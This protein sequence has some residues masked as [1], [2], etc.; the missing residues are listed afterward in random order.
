MMKFNISEDNTIRLAEAFGNALEN[1]DMDRFYSAFKLHFKDKSDFEICLSN[2]NLEKSNTARL[3]YFYSVVTQEIRHAGVVLIAI[4]SIMEATAQEEFQ[5]FDQWLLHQLKG[6]KNISFPINDQHNFKKMILLRQKEYYS[7][8]GSSQKVHN[9]VDNYFSDEDK[10]KLIGGFQ[11]RNEPANHESLNFDDKI[12]I[13]VDMLYKERN[14]FVHKARLPQLSDQNVKM[15]G[16][17]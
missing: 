17:L 5:P 13:I 2:L 12:K 15:L 3:G 8:H 9:F 4:F 10:Q 7:R 16:C 14:A 6:V 1:S 11:I